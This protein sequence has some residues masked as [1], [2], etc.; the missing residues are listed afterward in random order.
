MIGALAV[1]A[2]AGLPLVAQAGPAARSSLKPRVV[3]TLAV[4][5]FA[6]SL[7]LGRDGSLYASTTTWSA[8]ESTPSAGHVVKISPRTGAQSVVGSLDTLGFLTGLAFDDRGRLYVADATFSDTDLPGVFRVDRDGMTRV[9]TLPAESFPNGLAFRDGYLY[10][11]DSALGAIWRARPGA[12]S[13]LSK[14]WFR[15][16]KLGPGTGEEDHGIGAN[17][18]AVRAG[19]VYVAVADAGRIVRVPIL[20]NGNAGKLKVVAQ[21]EEL[22]S[23]DGIA[24]DLLG[25]LWLVTNGPGAGRLEV[26]T[27]F[28]ALFVLADQPSWLDY[29]TQPVFGTTPGTLG[30]LYIANGAIE[31]GA[32]NVVAFGGP[33]R[34]P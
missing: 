19:D 15:H 34:V 12:D 31:S 26:L 3:T 33:L 30:S 5:S 24:F 1:V 11:S 18:I 2:A 16:E 7:A 22:K 6:E 4:G 14:P 28:G 23:V 27:P 17:G 9:L 25:N 21:R 29:P 8:D 20:R 10:V 13:A 32:P